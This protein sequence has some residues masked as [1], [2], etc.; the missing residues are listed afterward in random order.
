[1][2]AKNNLSSLE[3]SPPAKAGLSKYDAELCSA[4][5]ELAH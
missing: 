2:Q 3:V 5:L 1:L 4:T